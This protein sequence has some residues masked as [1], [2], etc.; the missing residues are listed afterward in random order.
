MVDCTKNVG[1]ALT[2]E[3]RGSFFYIITGYIVNDSL[4][5]VRTARTI[6][7]I[8]ISVIAFFE[9]LLMAVF[10]R[11]DVTAFTCTR[12]PGCKNA[13][14]RTNSRTQT[15]CSLLSSEKAEFARFHVPG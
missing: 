3:G 8:L 1:K 4:L 2:P 15:S 6:R 13:Q 5:L 12:G 9:L 7:A 14:E 11:A 10:A